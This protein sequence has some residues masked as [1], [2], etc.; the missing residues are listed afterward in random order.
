MIAG[1]D[2]T[3]C[4]LTWAIY[5]LN[6]HPDMEEKVLQEI[7]ELLAQS[8][9]PTYE[10]VMHG[11]QYTHA[12]LSET[13]RLHPPV[14]SDTKTAVKD[15]VLPDGTF[16]PAGAKVNYQPYI[17]GRLESLWGP[18]VTEF[19]PERWLSMEKEPPAYKF[20]SFN[21]GPRLCLGKQL[22][23]YEAKMLL[24]MLLPK[25][26]FVRVAGHDPSYKLSIILQMKHGLPCHVVPR[27]S[28][29]K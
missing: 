13:L 28:E 5:E 16:I 14:P 19:K 1:R 8:K 9:Y 22:A 15:D 25:Y 3:A 26:K 27:K 7:H 24:A 6:E 29:R 21:G 18:D 12:F 10:S 17:F 4:L 23:Y 11:L 20:L 2:T